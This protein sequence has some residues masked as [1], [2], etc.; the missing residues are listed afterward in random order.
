MFATRIALDLQLFETLAADDHRPK[1]VKELAAVKNAS[2]KLVR[3]LIRHLTAMK[4]V[5]QTDEDEYAS[6]SISKLLALAK[7]HE[8]FRYW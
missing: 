8:G 1:S 6:N 2:P 4:M 7:Y 3:R 5:N